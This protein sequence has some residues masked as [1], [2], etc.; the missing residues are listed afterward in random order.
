MPKSK[1]NSKSI[2]GE[3]THALN[4]TGFYLPMKSD[5]THTNRSECR[6]LLILDL[7]SLGLAKILKCECIQLKDLMPCK[8]TLAPAPFI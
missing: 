7:S 1:L 3:L 4:K 2:H 5:L 6:K 8:A